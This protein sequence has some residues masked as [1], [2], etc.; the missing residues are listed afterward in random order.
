M[1]LIHSN[2]TKSDSHFFLHFRLARDLSKLFEI[3]LTILFLFITAGTCN[4]LLV[5]NL[6]MV[7]LYFL[8]NFVQ[9]HIFFSIGFIFSIRT[10]RV[11]MC[12]RIY[13]FIAVYYFAY[14]FLPL[15]FVNWA[16]NFPQNLK[17]SI[18]GSNNSNGICCHAIHKKWYWSY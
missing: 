3:I 11:S 13:Y 14:L 5:I 4:V 12:H 6:K 15:W 1:F 16:T 9:M 10:V 17:K 18:F 8:H 7:K 2:V